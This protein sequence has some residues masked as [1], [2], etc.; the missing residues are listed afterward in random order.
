[1]I[2]SESAGDLMAGFVAG[3]DRGRAQLLALAR[4]MRN[5]MSKAR[6]TAQRPSKGMAPGVKTAPG[7]PAVPLV[8]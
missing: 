7:P 6:S 4:S 8:A 5:L 1:M 3:L 2:P